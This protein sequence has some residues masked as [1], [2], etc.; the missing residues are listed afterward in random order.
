ML[1]IS[2]KNSNVFLKYFRGLHY[3]LQEKMMFFK[4]KSVGKACVHAQYLE[5]IRLK[6]EKSS[7]L[8]KKEKYDASKEGKKNKKGER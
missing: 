2:S 6:K 8:K 4:P 1:G 5:N 3:H 7:G